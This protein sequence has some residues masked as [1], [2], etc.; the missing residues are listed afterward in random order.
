MSDPV[1]FDS[2]FAVSAIDPDGKKFERGEL[3]HSHSFFIGLPT[4][5]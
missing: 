1:L 4:L 5:T 2:Q 3:P